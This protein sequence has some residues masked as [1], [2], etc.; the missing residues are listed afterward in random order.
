M[1][2]KSRRW[3]LFALAALGGVALTLAVTL[4]LVIVRPFEDEG[5]ERAQ[6]APETVGPA[7]TGGPAPRAPVRLDAERAAALG[8][9][10]VAVTRTPMSAELRAVVTIVPDE[11]LVSHVHTR[12][13]GWIQDLFIRTT[14]ERVRCEAP[15]P[16]D[17]EALLRF[18]RAPA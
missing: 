11:G 3:L 4:V 10:V 9:H 17:L 6:I 5:R 1:T 8:V 18:L 12:V 7:Q 15:L 16:A 13:S 2:K 14:G